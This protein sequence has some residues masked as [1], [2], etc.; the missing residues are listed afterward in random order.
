LVQ[1]KL[2]AFL[3]KDRVHLRDLI[4]VGLLDSTWPARFPAE[5]A[6]RLQSLLDRPEG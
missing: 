1:I 2:T 4:E 5:L 3:D 6:S